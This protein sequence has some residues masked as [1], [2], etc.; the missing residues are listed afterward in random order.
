[1]GTGCVRCH[2]YRFNHGF[3]LLVAHG[4]FVHLV[5][6]AEV[7]HH[8]VGGIKHFTEVGEK[9]KAPA[10]MSSSRFRVGI[11]ALR[12]C[13]LADGYRATSQPLWLPIQKRKFNFKISSQVFGKCILP[14]QRLNVTRWLM[15]TV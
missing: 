2:Q 4:D 7:A 14:P 1:M 15:S 3:G 11:I 12:H 5:L 9:P 6:L 13:S 8:L 10:A